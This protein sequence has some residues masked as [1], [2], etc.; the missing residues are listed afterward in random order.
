MIDKW[1]FPVNPAVFACVLT[2]TNDS[3]DYATLI[4]TLIDLWAE[5]HEI[6]K[7][8]YAAYIADLIKRKQECDKEVKK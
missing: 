7:V 5:D 3:R 2:C 6:D 1:L 4:C 8:M